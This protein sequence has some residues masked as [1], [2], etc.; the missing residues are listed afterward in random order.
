M[1]HLGQM[2]EYGKGV[3]RDFNLAGAWYSKAADAGNAD[4]MWRLAV[5]L[6][7]YSSRKD[8]A[9]LAKFAL[10]AAKKGSSEA[11]EGL[12]RAP[13]RSISREVRVAIE[14]Q[15]VSEGFY[16]GPTRGRFDR[17]VREAIET[18]LRGRQKIGG[19]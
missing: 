17:A 3:T 18:Y 19:G 7:K 6:D 1:L 9:M 5:L 10:Q 13:E 2:A 15:L 12:F 8:T 4:A 11:M 16:S 14:E